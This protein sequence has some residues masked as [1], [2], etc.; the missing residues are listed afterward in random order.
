MEIESQGKIRYT[1]KNTAALPQ[2]AFWGRVSETMK[3]RDFC[4][5]LAAAFA[6]GALAPCV[7]AQAAGTAVVGRAAADG[8]YRLFY[9][10]DRCEADLEHTYYYSDS[11]F[12]HAA[13]VYDNRLALATLG[14]TAAAFSTWASDQQY[15]MVGEVGRA[16]HIRDAFEQ[17]GFAEVELIHYDHS[18]NDIPDTVACAIARKTLVRNGSRVTIIAAFLR[19]AGYGAEWSGNLYAGAGSAHAGFVAAAREM[20]GQIQSY[21]KKSA[22]RHALGTLKFWMGGYSRSAA[23]ANLVAARLPAL[24]PQLTKKNT[25]VYTFAAPAALAAADCPELQQ[26]YD[27]NH[28]KSGTLKKN[29]GTSNIFNLISSG[30]IVPRVLPWQWGYHRNGNDRFLPATQNAAELQELNARGAALDGAPLAFDQLAVAE[31]TDLVVGSMLELFESRQ[32]YH[33]VYE[34][35]FRC[36]LQCACTRSEA[37]VAQGIILDD[38]AVV[39]RLRSM[40]EMQQFSLEKV[41]N[42]VQAASTMSRPVLARLGDSVPLMARQ[43]MIPLLAVGLCFNIETDALK[44]TVDFVLSMFAVEGQLN[45]TVRSAFCHYIENYATLLEYYAPSDHCMEPHTRK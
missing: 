2:E 27:N 12:D 44:L 24:L 38:D 9:R 3:R 41:Q 35:A 21:V 23:V 36:M 26:D 16:D 42:C 15:W 31:D 11:L 45:D 14:M 19:G 5:G 7:P 40:D 20:A 13:Q 1:E 43:M 25:F 32:N 18:L 30:D 17:L 37:E 33:N 29:W 4:K 39:E 10:S 6:A 8:N 28:N 22:S 34:E